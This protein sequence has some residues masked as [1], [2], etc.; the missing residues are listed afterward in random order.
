MCIGSS[1]VRT[2]RLTPGESVGGGGH[3][4]CLRWEPR[5]ERLVVGWALKG[6]GAEGAAAGGGV[7]VLSTR[8]TPSFQAHAIGYARTPQDEALRE[9][10][11][12]HAFEGDGVGGGAG[13]VLAV[14]S[15]EGRMGLVPI[16]Y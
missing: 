11:F 14:C 7:S 8:T 12:T 1:S 6:S 13:A 15:A 2:V 10:R 4:V 3:I 16:A 9:L 5:G